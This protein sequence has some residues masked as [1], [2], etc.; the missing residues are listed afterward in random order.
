MPPYAVNIQYLILSC[1]QCIFPLRVLFLFTEQ[2]DVVRCEMC[3]KKLA[4]SILLLYPPSILP[5]GCGI[6]IAAINEFGMFRGH[7]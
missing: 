2:A 4:G 5:T 7:Q 3:V 1:I 6:A